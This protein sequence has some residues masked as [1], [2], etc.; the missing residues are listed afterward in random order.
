M[1]SAPTNNKS[2]DN[3]AVRRAILAAVL[4]TLIPTTCASADSFIIRNRRLCDSRSVINDTHVQVEG[5]TI[6]AIGKQFKILN[7]TDG[8]DIA[9]ILFV[10]GPAAEAFE[11]YLDDVGLQ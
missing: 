6:N 1:T 3:Q 9:A 8:Y 11:F 10:G 5:G 2:H 7:G 4:A